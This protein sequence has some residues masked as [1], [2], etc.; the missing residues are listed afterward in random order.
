MDEAYVYRSGTITLLNEVDCTRDVETRP[1]NRRLTQCRVIACVANMHSAEE[2]VFVVR[3][4][5]R[6]I[7]F[8]EC[9]RAFRNKYGEGSVPT[10]SSIHK[11]VKKFETNGSVCLDTQEAGR[12]AIEWCRM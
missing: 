1:P 11:L 12:C 3:E 6:I 9:Q 7:L 2:R 8:K 4:Y 10:K 5:W